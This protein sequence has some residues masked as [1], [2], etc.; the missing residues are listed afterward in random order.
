LARRLLVALAVAALAAGAGARPL[1]NVRWWGGVLGLAGEFRTVFDNTEYS[2]LRLSKPDERTYFFSDLTLYADFHVAEGI[3]VQ[4]GGKAAYD[5]GADAPGAPGPAAYLRLRGTLDTDL[6]HW[7]FGHFRE[8]V[9]PLTFTQRDYDD[10]L[11]GMRYRLTWGRA[12]GRLF[13]AR[14]S[15]VGEERYETFAGGGR[16][17]VRPWEIPEVGANLGGVHEG[18]F[19]AGEGSAPAGGRKREAGVGSLDFSQEIWKGIFAAG[20][21]AVS[22]DRGDREE[23]ALR[24][25][26]YWLGLGWRRGPFEAGGRVY[27]VGWAFAAPLGERFLRNEEGAMVISDYYAWTARGAAT[28]K[29]FDSAYLTLAFE[30]GVKYKEEN[31]AEEDYNSNLELIKFDVYL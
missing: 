16:V 7:T 9:S 4:A 19:D 11:A 24:D 23:K 17:A 31:F 15:T 21:A 3:L 12:D 30:A 27:R 5:F 20:E 28:F 13:L 26:A 6:H 2:T 8:D 29:L 14:T 22:I 25:N 1:E 18:G 10:E